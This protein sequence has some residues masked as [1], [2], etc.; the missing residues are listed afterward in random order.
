MCN[1]P[2]GVQFTSAG[3]LNYPCRTSKVAVNFKRLAKRASADKQ[4]LEGF[5]ETA[6]MLGIDENSKA[7]ER[8]FAKLIRETQAADIEGTRPAQSMTKE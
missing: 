8:A 2:V 6:R 1:T 3:C 7:F 4:R 5:K